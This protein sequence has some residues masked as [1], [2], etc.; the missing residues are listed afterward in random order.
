LLQVSLDLTDGTPDGVLHEPVS[1][2]AGVTPPLVTPDLPLVG[3]VHVAGFTDVTTTAEVRAIALLATHGN[4]SA[5]YPFHEERSDST[6]LEHEVSD[7][8]LDTD[9][10]V[11]GDRGDTASR[12][13]AFA[14]HILAGILDGFIS[15]TLSHRLWQRDF[16]V[17]CADPD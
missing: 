8:G 16:H 17:S 2:D 11:L 4:V 7:T 10:A 12:L 1:L 14:L 5:V 6:F 9:E 3:D 13:P 15:D